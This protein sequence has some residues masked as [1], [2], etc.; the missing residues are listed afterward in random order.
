MLDQALDILGAED[1]DNARE[2]VSGITV[3]YLQRKKVWEKA[4]TLADVEKRLKDIANKA[5]V[6]RTALEDLDAYTLEAMNRASNDFG[7]LQL[8][9][10]LSND[11]RPFPSDGTER[12][13]DEIYIEERLLGLEG[14]VK[15]CLENPFLM[16][17]GYR[18]SMS[19]GGK[20][21]LL[22]STQPSPKWW[23]ASRC[24]DLMNKTAEDDPTGT[25]GGPY[26]RFVNAV[27]EYAT[28]KN[29]DEGDSLEAQVTRIP[30][31]HV[32]LM[33]LLASIDEMQEA[34]L[35]LERCTGVSVDVDI[36]SRI[37]ELESEKQ[38]ILAEMSTGRKPDTPKSS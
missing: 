5:K 21:T 19:K 13:E 9:S 20:Q 1:R 4:P 35:N 27:H 16:I 37:F 8:G 34:R 23:L 30:K 32:R 18:E 7:V 6:L 14:L 22:S 24:F 3:E 15:F 36:N 11:L 17:P 26:H 10:L 38:D 31:L 28:G 29:P 25:R 33:E 12:L 2:R